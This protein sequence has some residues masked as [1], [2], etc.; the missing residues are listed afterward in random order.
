[1]NNIS[2][3][4]S[5]TFRNRSTGDV[6]NIPT[7]I[8]PKTGKHII[9]WRDIQAGFDKAKGIWN[10]KSLVP[11]VIDE[12]LEQVV[13]LRITYHPEVVLDV[14]VDTTE[15]T[16][17]TGE[18][19]CV[20]QASS[21]GKELRDLDDR[22]DQ[23]EA[24]LAIAVNTINQSLVMY[25]K[26]ILEVP[27]TSIF[28][29]N[30]MH[31]TPLHTIMSS[32]A[33]IK[34]SIDQHFDRLQIEMDKNKQLQE[35]M[36][37]MQKTM[38]EKQD[39][40]I[41]MQRQTLDRLAIIQSRVQAILTQTYELHEYPIPR[42]FIVLPKAVGLRDKFK[43]LLSDQFRLYFLCECGTHTMSE[44]SK[45]PHE[46]HLAKHEGYDLDQPTE[47]FE[48]YGSYVL[49]LMQMIKYG[50]VAA[51]LVVPPLANFKIVDGLDTAQ[52]H[53][54]YLKKNIAPLV[55]DTIGFL[56]DIKS[57]NE[58]GSELATD[59]TEFEQLE[60]LEGA[61][62]RQ[63]GSYLKVKDKGCVLGNLYRIVTPEG[64]VKWVCFDHYKTSYRESAIRQLRDIIEINNGRFIEEKGRIEIGITSNTLAKQFYDAMVKARGIQELDITL[65][66]DATM[67]N[68]RSLCNA[69]TKANVIHL[70]VDGTHFKSSALD[71]I[72]RS[73]RY[74]PILQLA[75]NSRVQSLHLQGFDA[76]FSRISKSSLASA[77]KFR[78][79]VMDSGFPPNEKTI[80][81]FNDFLEQCPSLTILKLKI[82][83]HSITRT[84]SDILNKQHQLKLLEIDCG[85][86]SFSTSVSNG[87]IQDLDMTIE[88]LDDLN[89][90]GF[91][92]TQQ[93]HITRLKIANIPQKA[94]Q[95]RLTDILGRNLRIVWLE[96]GC[97][98]GWY[99]AINDPLEMKFQDLVM[100]ATS[101]TI[102]EMESLKINC[103][104]LSI[105]AR[106]LQGKLKDVDLTIG[107][108][109]ELN[110]DYL[111]FI[112]KDHLGRLT[113]KDVP[114]KG[115][116]DKLVDVLRHSSRLSQL[117]IG[118]KE[119][120][121]NDLDMKF[122]DLVKMTT[123]DILCKLE[124]LKINCGGL[125]INAS[126]SQ[127]KIQDVDL[128]I[129][130]LDELN[131]DYLK[132]IQ[133]NHLSRLAI[134]Y[135]PQEADED[136]LADILHSIP[137]LSHLQIG[138]KSERFFTIINLMIRTREKVVQ[139]KGL[140][141]LLSI[142]LM[143]ENLVPFDIF[144]EC[145]K[146]N[147]YIQSALSFNVDSNSF[148]M[149]TWIRLRNEMC[150]T[151][152][153]PVYDLIRRYGWSIVFFDENR[154]RNDT[155]AAILDDIPTTRDP[156]L[157]SFKF[158]TLY[159]QADGFDRLDRIIKRS[160][161][162]KDLGLY[163]WIEDEFDLG[164]A[165]SLLRKYGSMLSAL[166]L[167]GR[168]LVHWLLQAASSF[169]TR[170]S[171]PNMVSFELM[172]R[173]SSY[174]PSRCIPWIMA[175]VS[176]PPQETSSSQHPLNTLSESPSTGSWTAL[177]KIVL[178][179]ISLEPEEW[180]A[181]MRTIDL[182]ELQHLVLWHS[183]F[184]HESFKLLVDRIIELDNN[185]SNVPLSII[186]IPGTK[187]DR[188]STSA[189]FNAAL[190]ELRRKAPLVEIVQ[191][192][193]L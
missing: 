137:R 92:L 75:S 78:A 82:D 154:T 146:E 53:L 167:N 13:P 77:P 27:Q 62:L 61:D 4:P 1:M 133:K 165:Q 140:S 175:M 173:N 172:Y 40:A 120:V 148:D 42:L 96:I 55:E 6:A 14:V 108:L 49:T 97:M 99:S 34:Q 64:H 190:V 2:D 127:G 83:Q 106:F 25:P 54:E 37:Q 84:T 33:I 45:T 50:I 134:R 179:T 147:T 136:Q 113:I 58:M 5:Q 68:L 170:N 168:F 52:K 142:E 174:L 20:T 23:T 35:Q 94:D 166:Q 47:F 121:N 38:D 98:E 131:L 59:H 43:G 86:L 66:W 30:S 7:V 143:G 93:G 101:R 157:K 153:E 159:F 129:G 171:F 90:D 149:R 115:D 41:R 183:N 116:E 24:A 189:D 105:N 3:D 135:T 28:T 39:Q 158:N 17:S 107:E 19:V 178:M 125:S 80:K 31:A 29:H 11:F 176:A 73:Q 193:Y 32:Q 44:V 156:R 169:P 46:I 87:K 56:Q 100:I 104:G 160:P 69:I 26:R 102:R 150:I 10:G 81:S 8:D 188:S 57:N 72:N 109:N 67:D 152:E 112:Q 122:Q 139:D 155:F 15:Q 126:F 48:R 118:S 103:G 161:N 95:D 12:N 177:R 184:T 18:A 117:E 132:L 22:L 180:K 181:V 164:K 79:F 36:V 111:K 187:L 191:R 88:R 144:G 76:F 192:Q 110:S 21:T 9:L 151:D 16:I 123:V 89:S 182:F 65:K 138:C 71:L 141:C 70:T 63:L 51:G 162:F 119:A 128:T 85:E 186:N 145:D 163:M 91:K 185:V 130:R 60:A 74:D 114:R 124:S